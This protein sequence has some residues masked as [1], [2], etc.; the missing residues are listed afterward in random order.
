LSV[1]IGLAL[2]SLLVLSSFNRAPQV[3][4]LTARE[5]AAAPRPGFLYRY[6]PVAQSFFT[7][8]LSNN[9]LPI[10]VAVTGTNPTEVWVADYGLNQVTRVVFTSTVDHVQTTYAITST[11]GSGPYRIAVHGTDVWFTERGANRV[12]RLNAVTGQLD[13]FYGHGLSPNAGLSDIKVASDNTVWIGGQTVQ[14]LIRLTVNSS[15]NYTFTEYADTLRPYPNFVVEPAFLAIDESNQVWLTAPDKNYYQIAHFTPSTGDFVWPTLPI[16]SQPEGVVAIGGYAWCADRSRNVIAQV[17]YQT[18]TYVNSFGPITH[19]MEI[20]AESPNVFWVTEDD[21]RGSIARL[22]YTT[23]VVSFQISSA[24]LPAAG[25]RL[26]GI[27]V[28][29]NS[30]VWVA[31]YTPVQV[32]LPLV[33]RNS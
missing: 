33:L 13:E 1:A 3:E 2:I 11:A 32:Y 25:L 27:G 23:S 16:G 12:G 29:P 20:A 28:V 18:Y 22:V 24:A 6:D 14:R 9:A 5:T 19:P 30:G 8:T 31:A 7:I 10:G 15:S 21:G 26:T 4:A 17:V